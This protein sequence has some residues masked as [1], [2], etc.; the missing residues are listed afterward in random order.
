M[1]VTTTGDLT[2]IKK[3]NT[4]IV[5]E[6]VLKNAPLSR[7]QISELTGLNKAT[8]SNLVQDLIDSDLII[9]IG[10]GESSGGRKPVMLLFN[11][12]AGYAVGIDLGVNYIRGVLSDL[13][14]NVVAELQKSLKKHQLEFTLKELV[15]CI[16]KLIGKAPVSPYGIV[17]IGIGV[18]GI[19]DDQGSILFAPNLEWRDVE[20]QHMLEE[21]F[22]LPVTIDNEANAG[23]QGEQKYGIGRGIAHQIYVSVGIGIGTGIILN[24]ELYKGATG[25]SGELGHLSIEY[26]G[27]PCRCG[28][29]GCWELYASENALLEQAAPLGFDSLEDLL[30]AADAGNEEVRALFYKI[31]EYMGAGISNIVNVFNPDVVIIGNRMSRAKTWLEEAVQSSV[32]RRTLPYHRERL[33]IL[34]AE[35]QDQSA[36]RGAAYYAISKFFTKIKAG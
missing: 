29:E 25:F 32:A 23:A 17:G 16:E 5:L 33:K 30:E 31:G 34:F 20:L 35:L 28:N 12:Q 13:E 24:K 15:Q 2:L 22:Q 19:V 9:E 18:P 1:K 14:G 3:I 27:K 26:S 21:R 36:V 6:A 4:S 8:V 10:P 11:G 7:A